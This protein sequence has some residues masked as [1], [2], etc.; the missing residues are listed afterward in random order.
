MQA[1]LEEPRATTRNGPIKF[2]VKHLPNHL[3]RLVFLASISGA[4]TG[5]REPDDEFISK[6]NSLMSLSESGDSALKLPIYISNVI[7]KYRGN[8]EQEISVLKDPMSG[9]DARKECID[10]IIN[11]TGSWLKYGESELIAKDMTTLFDVNNDLF[12]HNKVAAY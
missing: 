2:L 3:K 8:I 10:K 12:K 9:C 6:L 1:Q 5:V 7:W 4:A 11:H